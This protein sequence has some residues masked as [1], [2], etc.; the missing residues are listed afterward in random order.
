MGG[1]VKGRVGVDAVCRA[2]VSHLARTTQRVSDSLAEL[3]VQ[4]PTS[5]T[6]LR[7]TLHQAQMHASDILFCMNIV[8]NPLIVQELCES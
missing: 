3:A 6:Y 7:Y 1:G 8:S 5:I 2:A 4:Q